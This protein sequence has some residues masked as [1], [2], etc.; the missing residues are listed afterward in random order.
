MENEVDRKETFL[1]LFIHHSIAQY[2]GQ[3]LYVIANGNGEE[4]GCE[5]LFGEHHRAGAVR[6]AFQITQNTNFAPGTRAS[7][8][9]NFLGQVLLLPALLVTAICQPFPQISQIKGTRN[10]F[11]DTK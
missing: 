7:S 4:K 11:M 6:P 9:G 10:P 1:Y 8:G 3:F 5:V 2:S